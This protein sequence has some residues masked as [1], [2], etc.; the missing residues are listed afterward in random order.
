[1][2]STNPFYTHLAEFIAQRPRFLLNFVFLGRSVLSGQLFD[3]NLFSFQP[4]RI[5]QDLC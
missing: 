2:C 5:S 3:S 4:V 1:M